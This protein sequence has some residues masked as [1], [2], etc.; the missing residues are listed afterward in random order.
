ML[1]VVVVL[2]ALLWLPYRT[3]V[4]VNSLT[5]P[6]HANAW[7]LLFCRVC[8]YGNS[9]VN[10]VIYNLMSQ[11]FRVAFRRLCGCE[12]RGGGEGKAA[13]HAPVYY[14]VIKDSLP[15]SAAEPITEQEDLRGAA[16]AAGGATS[17]A[18]RQLRRD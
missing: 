2:F 16:A 18:S 11:K 7:L 5:E 14:S 10:P 1:A 17:R 15:D 3:L 9:A 13:N 4:V 12:G 8:V 6:P